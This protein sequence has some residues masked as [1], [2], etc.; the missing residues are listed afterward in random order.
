LCL[1][2]NLSPSYGMTPDGGEWVRAAI[3]ARHPTHQPT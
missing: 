1:S 3:V 2:V